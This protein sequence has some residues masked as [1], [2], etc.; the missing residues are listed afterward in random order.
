MWAVL[1]GAG[2]VR[3]QRRPAASARELAVA[4]PGA[5]PLLEHERHTAGTLELEL[6]GGVR[7]LAT[8]FTP[9]VL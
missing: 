9:G 6:G 3:G 1:D 8:C 2:T 7:C 5:Y 4:H